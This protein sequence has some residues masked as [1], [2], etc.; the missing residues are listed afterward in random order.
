MTHCTFSC[1][2]RFQSACMFGQ[3]FQLVWAHK[4]QKMLDANS[5]YCPVC[6]GVGTIRDTIY[7]PRHGQNIYFQILDL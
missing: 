2:R 1:V 7:C 4:G 5:E 6:A 3:S